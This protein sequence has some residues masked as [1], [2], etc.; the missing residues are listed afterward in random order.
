MTMDSCGDT[1]TYVRI[2]HSLQTHAYVG[3]LAMLISPAHHRE[4]SRA[5]PYM[6][7][8]ICCTYFYGLAPEILKRG[9]S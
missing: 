8:A 2:R 5:E 7:L 3:N 4:L 6:D 9:N 1:A